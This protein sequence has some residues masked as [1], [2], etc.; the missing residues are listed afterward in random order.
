MRRKK[1]SSPFAVSPLVKLIISIGT[2][3]CL[4]F[5]LYLYHL[6]AHDSVNGMFSIENRLVPTN[7]NVSI[8]NPLPVAKSID[9][10]PLVVPP[11]VSEIVSPPPE[12]EIPQKQSISLN[13]KIKE[14]FEIGK[15][16]PSKLI[17]ILQDDNPFDLPSTVDS[18]ICPTSSEMLI[19]SPN[20][21]NHTRAQEFRQGKPGTW[22]FYQHL[23]K[24]GGTGFCDLAQNNLPR[25][26]TPPYFCMI[27]NRGSLATSPW[28]NE[29]YLMS[30]M[31][32][33][34][35]R[36]TANE[37]DAY[38]PYM[39]Q[40]RGAVLA[41]T[42]RHPVDRWYSQYRFEHLEHRDGS[43]QDAPR[44]PFRT[45]YNNNKGWT[46]VTPFP[47]LCSSVLSLDSLAH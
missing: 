33:S 5:V 25:Q 40:W 10:S 19:S 9:N 4:T 32:R 11:L 16:N 46:M 29:E 1:V 3:I 23:R 22:L 13:E 41:T 39:G 26:Q 21:I 42:F 34:N 7:A 20:L 43:K 36:I 17:H 44:R 31:E 6:P 12:I 2:L 38:Y 37:W 8:S 45:W 18:F 27:D 28:N 47:L 24:A 15:Q 14:L 35:Y 30:R